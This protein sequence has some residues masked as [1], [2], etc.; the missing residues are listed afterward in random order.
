MATPGEMVIELEKLLAQVN[1]DLKAILP[2]VME[3]TFTDSAVRKAVQ[4]AERMSRWKR[5]DPDGS[6][7]DYAVSRADIR[8][9]TEGE[10]FVVAD[11]GV[12][13]I[14]MSKARL[15]KERPF[16]LTAKQVVYETS[17]ATA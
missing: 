11:D 17:K 6:A 12:T 1:T 2:V 8:A 7:Y 14:I 4:E 10:P 16:G 15:V 9:K 5:C 3:P 13:L